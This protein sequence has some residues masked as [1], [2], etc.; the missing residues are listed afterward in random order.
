MISINDIVRH[1]N[2]ITLKNQLKLIHVLVEILEKAKGFTFAANDLC[3]VRSQ[4]FL[5]ILYKR[6]SDASLAYA[7]KAIEGIG[8]ILANRTSCDQATITSTYKELWKGLGNLKLLI[9]STDPMQ[10]NIKEKLAICEEELRKRLSKNELEELFP[11]SREETQDYREVPSTLGN[12]VCLALT[13]VVFALFL[14][15]RSIVKTS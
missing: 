1:T 12:F 8:T 2:S 10:Q 13:A 4:I 15:S 14:H 3:I 9:P 6:D 5:A 7:K 11:A